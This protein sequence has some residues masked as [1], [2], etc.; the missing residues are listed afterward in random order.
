MSQ[1]TEPYVREK[2]GAAVYGLAMGTASLSERVIDAM[3]I[4]IMFSPD[5][6]PDAWTQDRFRELYER[7]TSQE[8]LADEGSLTVTIN[9]MSVDDV[10][11]LARSIVDIES[12]LLRR[13]GKAD[14]Q[15]PV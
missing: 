2:F 6:M 5:D 1:M 9:G 10:Q 11:E 14:G 7:S 15:N 13:L 8:P 12:H 4:L 3:V